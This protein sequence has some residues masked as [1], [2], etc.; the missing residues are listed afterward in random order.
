MGREDVTSTV[1]DL[2]ELLDSA[3]D[4]VSC[5]ANVM[6]PAFAAGIQE[7]LPVSIACVSFLN[8]KLLDIFQL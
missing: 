7:I 6:G 2:D 1:E 8:E 4:L 5:M 3:A